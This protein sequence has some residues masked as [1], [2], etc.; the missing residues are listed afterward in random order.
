MPSSF[1]QRQLEIAPKDLG[2]NPFCTSSM[3]TGDSR[4][5]LG[6][7]PESRVCTLIVPNIHTLSFFFE[8]TGLFPFSFPFL[9]LR[10]DSIQVDSL[11][12]IDSL[13]FFLFSRPLPT[14]VPPCPT[15]FFLLLFFAPR[16]ADL[17]RRSGTSRPPS[18]VDK[19]TAPFF[20]LII[21]TLPG[22]SSPGCQMLDL[23]PILLP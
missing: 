22:F 15:S 9:L 1:V 3:R 11:G 5:L 6:M 8:R 16:P 23:F 21:A 2:F 14:A 18:F 4:H 20:Y 7:V 17:L 12:S 19:C 10:R 13:F